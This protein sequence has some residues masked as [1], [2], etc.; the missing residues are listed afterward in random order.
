MLVGVAARGDLEG[1]FLIIMLSLVDTF[2]QN[3]IGNPAANRAVVEYF[4]SYLPMQIVAGGAIADRVAWWQFWG[5]L[6]WAAGL[7][8]LGLLGFW[9]RTRIAR[10]HV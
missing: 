6:G 5:S 3:P 2:L 1:F 4:P 10:P 7:G 9:H 8:I